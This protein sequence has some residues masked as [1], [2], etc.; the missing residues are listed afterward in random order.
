M[1]LFNYE[2]QNAFVKRPFFSVFYCCI[3]PLGIVGSSGGQ[4]ESVTQDEIHSS[5]VSCIVNSDQLSSSTCVRTYSLFA[6]MF[7]CL[8]FIVYGLVLVNGSLCAK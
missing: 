8:L 6:T 3:N 7:L 4:L 5:C 1:V 2:Y